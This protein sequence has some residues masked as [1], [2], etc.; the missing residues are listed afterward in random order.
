MLLRYI[1]CKL[2]FDPYIQSN[3]QVQ[4]NFRI[5]P[6]NFESNRNISEMLN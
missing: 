4:R 6:V 3:R 1:T 2:E 5:P